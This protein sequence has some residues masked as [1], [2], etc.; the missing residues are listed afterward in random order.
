MFLVRITGV[1]DGDSDK[2][3][4]E[5]GS[6]V[7]GTDP[8]FEISADKSAKFYGTLEATTSITIGGA[9]MSEADLEQLDGITAGTAAAN[10]AVV[11]DGSKNIATIGTIGCGAITSSSIIKTDDTT[12]AS[13]TTDGS[14]QTDGGLSVAKNAVIGNDLK[15]LSDSAVLSLGAGNDATLTHDGATGLTI[16]A[17]PI[18]IVLASAS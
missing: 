6:G 8:A 15:L 14:L 12:E 1:E 3:V 10:K 18:S 4:I 17:S 9:A 13:S 5:D 16:A 7:L 11:L 2:F